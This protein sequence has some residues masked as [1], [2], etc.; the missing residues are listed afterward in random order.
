MAVRRGV[1]VGGDRH[2]LPA[3][4]RRARRRARPLTLSLTPVLCDQLEAPGAMERCLAFLRRD[5]PES[6]R[7]DIEE[8]RAGGH[9]ALARRAGA[10]RGRVRGARPSGCASSGARRAARGARRRT[11]AGPRRPPTRSCRCWPPTPA[12]LLQVQTGRGLAP[13]ALRRW[14]A[15]SGCPSAPTRRGSTRCSRRPGCA[16]RASS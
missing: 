11:P 16:P 14:A 2:L 13:A 7:L 15:G 8:L 9:D 1:A 6:H 3:A 10:L 5:P 12:S 4:A